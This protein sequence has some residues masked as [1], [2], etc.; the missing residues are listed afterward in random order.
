MDIWLLDDL[1]NSIYF[2]NKLLKLLIYRNILLLSFNTAINL[3]FYAIHLNYIKNYYFAQ[4][5]G[6]LR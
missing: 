2:K 5:A 1:D 3:N 6:T 4:R